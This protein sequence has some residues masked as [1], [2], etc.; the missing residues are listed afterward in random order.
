M[1][2]DKKQMTEEEFWRSFMEPG[3]Y[4]INQIALDEALGIKSFDSRE[5]QS[6]GISNKPFTFTRI[7][8]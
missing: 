2:I 7:E 8:N 4:R 6:L 3:S 1:V 5:F